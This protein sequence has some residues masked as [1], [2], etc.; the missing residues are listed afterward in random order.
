MNYDL[1][2]MIENV[3]FLVI[4]IIATWFALVINNV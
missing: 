4:L 2:E 3:V 1:K